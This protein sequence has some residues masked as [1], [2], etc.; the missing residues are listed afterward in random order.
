MACMLASAHGKGKGP[1]LTHTQRRV[2]AGTS[3]Q[4][5]R[6]RAKGG[7]C[8]ILTSINTVLH[9]TVCSIRSRIH[10]LTLVLRAVR[11]RTFRLPDQSRILLHRDIPR[12]RSASAHVRPLPPTAHHWYPGICRR[13]EEGDAI[14]P[15]QRYI[16]PRRAQP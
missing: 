13:K 10:R 8:Q 15:D 4:R 11:V 1:A 16:I 2:Q 3:G 14:P 7:M 5:R 12:V 9:G 6:V